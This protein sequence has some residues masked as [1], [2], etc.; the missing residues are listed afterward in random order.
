MCIEGKWVKQKEYKEIQ[1][2]SGQINRV[3]TINR[4][5]IYETTNTISKERIKKKV[6]ELIK[7]D[8][9]NLVNNKKNYEDF[10]KV[11]K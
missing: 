6:I 8:I 4:I 2:T 7:Q 11:C 5:D 1:L 3:H 10:K 9:Q